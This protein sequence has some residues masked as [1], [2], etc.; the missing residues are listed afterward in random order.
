MKISTIPFPNLVPYYA[1][2]YR[3]DLENVDLSTYLYFL[4]LYLCW[5][6]YAS[7]SI[8]IYVFICMSSTMISC[9]KSW[10]QS[11]ASFQSNL[12]WLTFCSVVLHAWSQLN[13][14]ISLEIYLFLSLYRLFNDS[15]VGSGRLGY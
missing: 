15:Q 2:K 14:N 3:S 10:C 11:T 1:D 5:F 4:Y 6:S 13:K 8:S 9:F 7:I 12:V